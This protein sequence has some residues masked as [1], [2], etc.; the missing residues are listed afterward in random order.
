MS[1]SA[2]SEERVANPE[3]EETDI[4]IHQVSVYAPYYEQWDGL[5]DIR[6]TRYENTGNW[7]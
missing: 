7:C 6:I 5:D 1:F 2:C 3:E 4:I